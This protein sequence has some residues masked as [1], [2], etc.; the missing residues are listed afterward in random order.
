M[1][2]FGVRDKGEVDKLVSGL[3]LLALDQPAVDVIKLIASPR[4]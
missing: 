2:S 1:E 4:Q 3:D